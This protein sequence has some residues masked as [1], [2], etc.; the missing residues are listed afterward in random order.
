M[1]N[2]PASH[3]KTLTAIIRVM[4]LL[5]LFL[6]AYPFVA[7]LMQ[8]NNGES[9]LPKIDISGIS[10]GSY[11]I[12]K[13]P[14][15]KK[16]YGD[17]QVS[18]MLV[19]KADGTVHAWTVLVRKGAVGMPDKY[20]WQPIYDCQQFGPTLVNGKIDERKPLECHDSNVAEANRKQDWQWSIDGK[21]LSTNVTDM[22]PTQGTVE[23]DYFVPL[24]SR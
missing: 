2:S 12:F 13:L 18:M 8:S 19:K 24:N 11:K 9:K 6:L 21:A 14:H 5:G 4:A 1:T 20:W 15:R 22:E 7:S 17:Y 23:G 3:K 10:P 16:M